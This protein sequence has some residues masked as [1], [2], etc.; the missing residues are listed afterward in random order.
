LL[1]PRHGIPIIGI[2][3]MSKLLAGGPVDDKITPACY[4][5]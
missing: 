2:G 4:L 1:N 5:T 3:V